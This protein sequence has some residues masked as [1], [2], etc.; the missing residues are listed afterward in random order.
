MHRTLFLTFQIASTVRIL[1]LKPCA[2]DSRF[3]TENLPF[4]PAALLRR[5]PFSVKLRP[6][7]RR[8]SSR[9]WRVS[10]FHFLSLHRLGVTA[11][12]LQYSFLAVVLHPARRHGTLFPS[13]WRIFYVPPTLR[14]PGVHHSTFSGLAAMRRSLLR[15]ILNSWKF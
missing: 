9:P 15:P 3:L 11:Q 10:S 8:R 7:V 2:L 14:T 1:G 6:G 13:G 4:F 12:N 5:P